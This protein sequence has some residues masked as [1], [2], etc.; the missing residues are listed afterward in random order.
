[1]SEVVIN[2]QTPTVSTFSRWIVRLFRLLPVGLRGKARL[3]RAILSG[4]L[5]SE[6]AITDQWGFTYRVPNVREPIAFALLVDGV[7]EP[8]A[9]EFILSRLESGNVFVDVWANI[10]VFTLPAA[11]RVGP[12]GKVL[13]IE[14][15]PRIFE[16]LKTNVS[17]AAVDNITCC[18]AAAFAQDGEVEFYDAPSKS[19][20][21][22]SLVRRFEGASTRVTARRLDRI[23]A[24]AAVKRVDVIKMDVEVFELGV[25]QGAEGLLSR[26]H[27]P[28][29]VFEFCDWAES[30]HESVV[31][32]AQRFLIKRGFSIWRLADF[33]KGKPP[34]DQPVTSGFETLVASKRR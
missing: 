33:I 24:E 21:M 27:P 19:F 9:I 13:A 7:Y 6:G 31:G 34:L 15:S 26:E 4:S 28:L 18:H 20:G 8:K 32:D 17:K 22:G 3:A 25:L 29:I 16:Y 11:R 1:M 30:D 2:R 23:V 5:N 14:A 12:Q 10:G